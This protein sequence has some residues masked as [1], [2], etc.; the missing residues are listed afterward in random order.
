MDE[1]ARQ[2]EL[3][4]QTFRN[5]VRNCVHWEE[6]ARRRFLSEAE[7][8]GLTD[9][10]VIDLL[11]DWVNF[12]EDIS[13][14]AGQGADSHVAYD[15][16]FSTVIVVR[17]FASNLYVKLALLDDDNDYPEVVIVSCHRAS[18]PRRS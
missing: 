16:L 2:L 3:V 17:G 7:F 12:A 6:P 14:V 8:A 13:V 4:L 15:H 5:G 1:S 18:H 9:A 10:R 11:I